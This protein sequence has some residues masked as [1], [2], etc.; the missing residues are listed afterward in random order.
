M[1][2]ESDPQSA[3]RLQDEVRSEIQRELA[4]H[5]AR[6]GAAELTVELRNVSLSY[7]EHQVL[8]D[9][10]FG[11]TRGQI[12]CVLGGSGVGK[13]TILRLILGLMPPDNGQILVS[14]SDICTA[15]LEEVLELREQMGMVFQG[16]ALFDSLSVFD[17]GDEEIEARVSHALS[18]V[19][20]DP[21]E[22]WDLLPAELSGGMRKRVGIARAIIHEPPILLFDEPTSGLDPVTTRT[23]DELILKLRRELGVSAVIVTHNIRSAARVANRVGL[24]SEGEFLFM[25]TP[26]EMYAS[27]DEYVRAFLG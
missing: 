4:E 8:R 2:P 18:I 19:D 22:V 7:G 3:S 12:L 5:P 1:K 21:E 10:S 6:A 9:L 27:D 13:S 16:S 17:L 14:G 15:S 26:E 11:V 20:L 24:L 23:I 25:G